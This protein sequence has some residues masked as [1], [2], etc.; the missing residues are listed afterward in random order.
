[1]R[2]VAKVITPT[3]QPEGVGA[4]VRRI[5]GTRQLRNLDPFLMLDHFRVQKP[6]GFPD[7][8]HRGFETVTYMLEG[9]VNHEDFKGN[10]GQIRPGDTQWMTAGRGIVHAE[11]PEGDQVN[12]GMQLWVNLHSSNK[13]CDPSY[14]DL[15]ADQIPKPEVD[16]V[17]VAIIAGQS[18][19]Q[20][21]TT[22]TKTPTLYLDVTMEPGK[23]FVQDIAAGWNGF[24]YV[25][26]GEVSCQDITLKTHQA[27]VLSTEQASIT[28]TSQTGSRF[29]IIAGQPIGEEVV[30]HGPFVMNTQEQI[31]QTFNDY[32]RSRNGFEGA[33]SWQS[34]IGNQ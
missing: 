25:V 23:T 26:G 28:L 22:I 10:K 20:Q 19:G 8:P 6:A 7:H 16:G 3:E 31:M 27:G 34:E 30:Q 14:Q 15:L 29:F 32:Q 5:I 24:I 2:K 21:A 9:C 17:K 12:V 1:M 4:V 18:L 13:M 11:M 33:S